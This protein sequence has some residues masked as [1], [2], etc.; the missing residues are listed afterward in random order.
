MSTEPNLLAVR[1]E[2]ASLVKNE[3]DYLRSFYEQLWRRPLA[4]RVRLGRAVDGL[5]YDRVSDEKRR[6]LQFHC[7]V[8][9]SRFRAG[10]VLRL[11]QNTPSGRHYEVTWYGEDD[12]WIGV[13]LYRKGDFPAFTQEALIATE[14]TLDESYVDLLG[15]YERA[16]GDLTETQIGR[17]QVLPTLAGALKPKVDLGAFDQAATELGAQQMN[18]TQVEAA[19][20]ALASHPYA[21]IQG[22]PGTGKTRTLAR[23]VRQL[24]ER[25]ERVLVTALTHRAIHEALNKVCDVV[26]PDLVA[27]IGVPI[28]DPGLTTKE[29]GY[30]K[31]C[32]LSNADSG[33]V[34]GATPFTLWGR[35]LQDVFFDTVIIDE[36]SQVTPALATMAMLKARRYVFVGDHQQLPPVIAHLAA[37]QGSSQEAPSIFTRLRDH[38]SSTLLTTCYRMNAE[39]CQWSS[40]TFYHQ[41]LQASPDNAQR[42]LTWPNSDGLPSTPW[43]LEPSSVFIR[44]D[45]DERRTDSREEAEIVVALLQ[46]WSAGGN[47]P[48]EIGVVVPYRRQANR[49]RRLLRR[50]FREHPSITRQITIDTVDRF[51]GSEREAM[52]LSFTASDPKFISE[53]VPFLFQA[54]RLN[55]A[56]TRARS[57]RLLLVSHGLIDTAETLASQGNESAALFLSLLE[58]ATLA[59]WP[60]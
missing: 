4:K 55:V 38:A 27:K 8:N 23:I 48:S 15:L 57:K 6:V 16:L 41:R 39:L 31:D 14:W 17:D 34:I 53:Q 50:R 20:M 54:Q 36:S 13:V 24:V 45:H 33:Y 12:G 56:V 32:P 52:I 40:D 59:P 9:E 47:S 49:I 18:D 58:D 26:S 30:F 1:D 29:F 22:P 28:Y 44:L 35:R 42:T 21:L 60:G 37:S 51:Q 10:D 46:D 19:A 2:L 7:A 11:S 5:T 25:G 3:H 43:N